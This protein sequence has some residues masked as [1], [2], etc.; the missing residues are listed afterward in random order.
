MQHEKGRVETQCFYWN[1]EVKQFYAMGEVQHGSALNFFL[2][3][4]CY[5]DSRMIPGA[6]IL[7]LFYTK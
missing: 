5:V 2:E 1:T 7:V 3:D 6:N 4:V